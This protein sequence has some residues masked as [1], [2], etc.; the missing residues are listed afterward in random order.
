MPTTL[1]A[2]I[3]DISATRPARN[4]FPPNF[5]RPATRADE[6]DMPIDEDPK[7]DKK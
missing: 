3:H 6:F 7:L 4:V 5:Y 1:Q 2:Q